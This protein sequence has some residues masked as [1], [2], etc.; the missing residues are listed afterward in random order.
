MDLTYT[1]YRI[2]SPSPCLGLLPNS[3]C[4]CL[5]ILLCHTCDKVQH[6]DI[7]CLC[8]DIL[9]C[10][11]CDKVRHNDITYVTLCDT[12]PQQVLGAAVRQY[13]AKGRPYNIKT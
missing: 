4:L 8:L 7:K 2:G 12:L 3:R 5:D 11:T 9:L 6:N 10:H 1:W 13:T